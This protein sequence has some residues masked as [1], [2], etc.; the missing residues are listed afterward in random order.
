MIERSIGSLLA[1]DYPGA[2]PRRAGR[3]RQRRRHRRAARPRWLARTGRLTVLTGRPLPAGWTGKLWAVSQGVE[4]AGPRR[5]TSGSPTPTSPMTAGQ[6]APAG[7]PRR[8]RA[9]RAG[10]ADGAAADRDAGRA[11]AD[12]RLRL[13]L[14]HALPVR[15]RERSE[16]AGSPRRRAAACWPGATPWSGGRH[17]RDPR[18][19]HRRLRA[20]RAAESAGPDLARPHPHLGQPAALPHAGRDRPDGLALGLCPAAAIR[21][22]CWRGPWPAWLLVY[23]AAPLLAVFATRTR[24][25]AGR[26]RPGR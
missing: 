19:D 3:R 9:A 15:L 1:Q 8:G 21:P 20:G 25:L 4:A 18:R 5:P 24:A 10:L 12:P 14:R 11:A 6:S 7:R 2:L 16:A 13:L 22:G 26:S 17:R 23:L